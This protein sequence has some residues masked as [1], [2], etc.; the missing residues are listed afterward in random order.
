MN[1]S[2]MDDSEL[3]SVLER[4]KLG[5]I[6]SYTY[7]ISRFQKRIFLYC[8]YLLKSH[9][10]AEDAAQD[11]FIKGLENITRF[12]YNVSFSAWLYTIA[13]NHCTDLL[14][15]RSKRYKSLMQYEINNDYKM[16]NEYTD[17]IHDL[18][19]NLNMEERQI[20]LLRSLE[21]YSYDEIASIMDI[22][23]TTIRKKYERIRK[24]LIQQ[25]IEGGKIYEHSY[26]TGG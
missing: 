22:K 13:R 25:K 3:M 17:L 23:P 7:I 19:D 6:P 24:K 14:K 5:D 4:I 10:E 16:E 11:I 1:Q 9:E 20:L 18:L 21:E 8:Y 12:S 2:N 15:I 26:K